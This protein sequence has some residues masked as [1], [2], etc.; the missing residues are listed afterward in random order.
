M[1]PLDR[2]ENIRL[3]FSGG[4]GSIAIN[5]SSGN[6]ISNNASVGMSGTVEF[7]NIQATVYTKA[8]WQAT[9]LDSGGTNLIGVKGSDWRA[10]A[11]RITGLRFLFSSGTGTGKFTLFASA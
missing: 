5:R 9:Y 3:F 2:H 11:D 7:E 6:A 10:E 4:S 1:S 8:E